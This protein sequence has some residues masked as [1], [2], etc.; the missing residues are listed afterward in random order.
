[1]NSHS[2]IQYLIYRWQAMGRHGMHSPFVY[3][4]VEDCIQKD[5]QLPLLTRIRT[6]LAHWP[7]MI[8]PAVTHN[9]WEGGINT[10]KHDFPG[11]YMVIVEGIHRSRAHTDSWKQLCSS[12]DIQYSIDLYDFGLLFHN[13]EF[14]EK[15]HFVLKNK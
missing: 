3:A 12:M 9:E 8:L 10:A 2:F 15:Q 1:L 4:L 14:K 7:V 13:P 5:R 6:F 11:I